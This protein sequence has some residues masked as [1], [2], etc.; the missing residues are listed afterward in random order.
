[1][2]LADDLDSDLDNVFFKDA[3]DFNVLAVFTLKKSGGSKLSVFGLFSNEYLEIEG[4]GELS[5]DSSVVE[6]TV[7][8]A[9]VTQVRRGDSALIDSVNYAVAS[10]RA[11]GVGVTTILLERRDVS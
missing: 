3:S 1:M 11:D 9:I 2:S 7:K 5:S 6:F 10:I 4:P 8:T